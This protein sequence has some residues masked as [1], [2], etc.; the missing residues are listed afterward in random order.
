MDRSALPVTFMVPRLSSSKPYSVEFA[1]L[2]LCGVEFCATPLVAELTTALPCD[3][4]FT[5]VGRL[6]GFCAELCVAALLEAKFEAGGAELR[7]VAA[8]REL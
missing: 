6:P 3:A 4:E 7:D 2:P 1:A 5:A 8:A